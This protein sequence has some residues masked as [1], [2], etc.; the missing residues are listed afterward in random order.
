MRLAVVALL[1][2]FVVA[3]PAALAEGEKAPSEAGIEVPA[4][5]QAFFKDYGD[6]AKRHPEA[7]ARFSFQDRALTEKQQSQ[8]K[9][10]IRSRH[11]REGECC[12]VIHNP[13]TAWE[14]CGDCFLC[15]P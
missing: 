15:L 3:G 14:T 4:E 7:A 13:G 1:V 10:F 11:C 9:A 5:L 2:L 6:L 8:T 12:G